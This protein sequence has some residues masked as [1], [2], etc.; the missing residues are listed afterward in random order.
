[1]DTSYKNNQMPWTIRQW[2]VNVSIRVAILLLLVSF[3]I[4]QW[5]NKSTIIF[6]LHCYDPMKGLN[7]MFKRS[8]CQWDSNV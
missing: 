7:T 4:N 5:F 6:Q 1:M 8:I 3:D 2:T